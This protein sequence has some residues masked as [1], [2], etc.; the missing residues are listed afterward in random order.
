MGPWVK[1]ALLALTTNEV[2]AHVQNNVERNRAYNQAQAYALSV[3]KPFLVV[4]GP[5]GTNAIRHLF[6]MRAHGCGDY[7]LDVDAMACTGCQTVVADVRDIP[8]SDSFFGAA[9]ASH[10]IEHMPTVADGKKAISEMQRVADEIFV[11]SP[12]K[13]SLIAWIHP[14]HH[15]WVKQTAEGVWLEQR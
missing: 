6:H 2:R 10:V 14:D 1:I 8:F 5:E 11:V 12:S 15:L 4:G 13:T 9:F 3:G 7:C